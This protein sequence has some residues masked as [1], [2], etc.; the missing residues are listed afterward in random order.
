[1]G[2]DVMF[3]FFFLRKGYSTPQSK[4]RKSEKVSGEIGGNMIRAH[5][6]GRAG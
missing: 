1:M 5:G 6:F 3:S 4:T 2:Y